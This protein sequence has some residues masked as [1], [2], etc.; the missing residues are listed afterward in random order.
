MNA[1]VRVVGTREV[2]PD[3]AG[4]HA[5]LATRVIDDFVVRH[6]NLRAPRFAHHV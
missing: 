2:D 4:K 3:R 1:H 5:H 6:S